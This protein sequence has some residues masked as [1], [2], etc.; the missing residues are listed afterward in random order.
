MSGSV[1]TICIVEGAQ[2]SFYISGQNSFLDASSASS[3]LQLPNLEL[4]YRVTFN[5]DNKSWSS[6]LH[7]IGSKSRTNFDAWDN[8]S[9]KCPWLFKTN[10]EQHETCQI[11]NWNLLYQR[12]DDI[13]GDWGCYNNT[14]GSLKPTVHPH[15]APISA[16]AIALLVVF[17]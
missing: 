5:T 7:T 3:I 1:W 9:L 11:L 12:R 13:W 4:T 8:T 17:S 16:P 10:E 2:T 6:Y 15:S 14:S